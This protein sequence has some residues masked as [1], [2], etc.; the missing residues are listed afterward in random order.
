VSETKKSFREQIFRVLRSP[1]IGFPQ[2]EEDDLRKGNLRYVR[3]MDYLKEMW[4]GE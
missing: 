3:D 1:S 4:R 2:I